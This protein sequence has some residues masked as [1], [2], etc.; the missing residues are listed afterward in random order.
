MLARLKFQMCP[1]PLVTLPE[2]WKL[3]LSWV[4]RRVVSCRVVSC[5]VVSCR[6][7]SCRVV[8]CRVVSCRVVSCRVVSCRVLYCTGTFDYFV[9]AVRLLD[10]WHLRVRENENKMLAKM[11]IISTIV[12]TIRPS[13]PWGIPVP[14]R[15]LTNEVR[16]GWRQRRRRPIGSERRY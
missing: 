15:R 10:C 4:S 5:R 2:R 7:V 11:Y 16:Y 8:S 13:P 9:Y 3:K 14:R 12:Y 6:V 1:M